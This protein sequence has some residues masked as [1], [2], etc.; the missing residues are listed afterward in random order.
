MHKLEADGL[1]KINVAF[2]NQQGYFS[3]GIF[4][5]ITWTSN[6]SGNKGSANIQVLTRDNEKYLHIRQTQTDEET[7]EK[8]DHECR[9]L[10]TTTSCNYGGER[11][12]FI[13]P[14]WDCGRRVGTLFL[15]ESGIACRHCYNLT[16]VTRNEPRRYRKFI[17]IPDLAKQEAKVKYLYYRNK[18]TRKYARYLQMLGSF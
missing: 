16:Y 5:T 3:G 11:Y 8:S 2:L 17:S 14:T 12:W 9:V 13:C 1:R 6:Y 10:L 4:G 7:E 18:P 15:V